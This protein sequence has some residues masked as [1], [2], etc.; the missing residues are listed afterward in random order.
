M[1][2]NVI[3]EGVSGLGKTTLGKALTTHEYIK[4]RKPESISETY[5]T[6]LKYFMKI[7]GFA[8]QREKPIV[9]DRGHI[10]ELV[11]GHLYDGHK[12]EDGVLDHWIA[13]MELEVV[14]N[15]R[16]QVDM[17]PTVIVYVE[18]KAMRLG[19][20]NVHEVAMYERMLKRTHLPVI[21]VKTQTDFGWKDTSE[22]INEI[23]ELIHGC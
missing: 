10:T 14:L 5:Y 19:W 12:Y 21:R 2:L 13:H 18:P 17:R 20:H 7:N 15:L 11:Y 1:D 6:Y 23:K 3:I 4:F 16:K 9:F 8:K 22:V